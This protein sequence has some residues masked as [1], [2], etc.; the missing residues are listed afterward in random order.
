MM[1]TELFSCVCTETNVQIPDIICEDK[2]SSSAGSQ[3]RNLNGQ[4]RLAHGMWLHYVDM[5]FF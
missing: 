1:A 4:L 3:P 2:K 5:S